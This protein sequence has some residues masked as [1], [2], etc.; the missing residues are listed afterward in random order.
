MGG[1]TVRSTI[2][3]NVYEEHHWPNPIQSFDLPMDAM[4]R[5]P[6]FVAMS[7][8]QLKTILEDGGQPY[9]IGQVYRN[10]EGSEG[11]SNDLDLYIE[12]SGDDRVHFY[13]LNMP[14]IVLD[15]E[16][17][18]PNNDYWGPYPAPSQ[19]YLATSKT[20][21]RSYSRE[22]YAAMGDDETVEDAAIGADGGAA[23]ADN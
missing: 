7:H 10:Y 8:E 14:R 6:G 22:D 5:V 17:D 23:I 19:W 2:R 18:G 1:T 21:V 11:R 15:A 4:R 13:K 16:A 3:P 20:Y 12:Y 9:W